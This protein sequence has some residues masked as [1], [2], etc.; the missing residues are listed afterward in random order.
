MPSILKAGTLVIFEIRSIGKIL[1][2]SGLELMSLL[3]N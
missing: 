2:K 3:L 1:V